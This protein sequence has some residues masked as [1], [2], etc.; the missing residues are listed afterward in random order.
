VVV[1]SPVKSVPST[2]I[3]QA[4][5]LVSKTASA[6]VIV[7][8]AEVKRKSHVVPSHIASSDV[9]K[10]TTTSAAA[11]SV[12]SVVSESTLQVISSD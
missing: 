9:F 8:I 11:L 7:G 12:A 2:T 1:V 5:K 10:K 3:V 6:L 4:I